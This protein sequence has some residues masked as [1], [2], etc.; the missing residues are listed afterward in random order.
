MV[1]TMAKGNVKKMY[2]ELLAVTKELR[3]ANDA[4]DVKGIDRAKHK[5][6]DIVPILHNEP[7]YENWSADLLEAIKGNMLGKCDLDYVIRYA[8]MLCKLL[9]IHLQNDKEY[10][11]NEIK[12]NAKEA[13]TNIV[14]NVQE[15]LKTAQKAVKEEGPKYATMAKHVMDTVKK[16]GPEY[17]TEA[18]KAFKNVSQK[19]ENT[20]NDL[21]REDDG[22]DN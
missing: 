10:K 18:T 5:M 7:E 3:D 6:L 17:V 9:E 15:R 13:C 2:E 22:D 14:H 1:L 20:I 21:M 12:E 19:F 4:G 16:K 11:I 8:F